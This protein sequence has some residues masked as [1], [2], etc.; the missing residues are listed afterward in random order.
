MRSGARQH[1][2]PLNS[3]WQI[4]QRQMMENPA[5]MSVPDSSSRLFKGNDTCVHRGGG[6]A[7][8]VHLPL[9]LPRLHSSDTS[10]RSSISDIAFANKTNTKKDCRTDVCGL[11]CKS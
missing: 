9:F 1:G 10:K 4:K 11:A 7:V 3:L 2:P 8:T 5:V 6:A